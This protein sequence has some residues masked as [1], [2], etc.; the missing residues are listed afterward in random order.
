MAEMD[1]SDIISSKEDEIKQLK[2]KIDIQNLNVK[3]QARNLDDIR[4]TKESITVTSPYSEFY[5]SLQ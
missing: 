3:E 5:L 2:N 1:L 4:N